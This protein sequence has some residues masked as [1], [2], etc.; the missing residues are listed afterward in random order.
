MANC[1]ITN[2]NTK[3]NNKP[4]DNITKPQC[5][6]FNTCIG[7]GK[8]IS[9]D[10]DCL[11]SKGTPSVIDGWYSEIH[12][13]N[14]CIIDARTAPIPI[15]TPPPCAPAAKPCD[16]NNNGGESDIVLNPE[17]CNLLEYI[18]GMLDARIYFGA[19]TGLTVTGCGTQN[20]PLVLNVTPQTQN[21]YIQSSTPQILPISGSGTSSDPF[22]ISHADSGIQA[23]M[24]GSFEVDR[25]GHIIAYDESR[26]DVITGIIDGNG[27]SLSITSGLLS[28]DLNDT[29]ID[30]GQYTLG[31]YTVTFNSTGQA[32][33]IRRDITITQGTYQLGNYNVTINDIG[34][35]T[36]ISLVDIDTTA[37][38]DT[39]IGS[40]RGDAGAVDIEREISFT[41][42]F[43]G[44]LH[45]EYRGLLS[46]TNL[47]P[48]QSMT[49]PSGFDIAIDGTS[50]VDQMI[51]VTGTFN[52]IVTPGNTI[53][54][55][56]GTSLN[57]ID[58]GPHTVTI[59]APTAL[60][61]QTDGV[62]RVQIVGKGA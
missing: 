41:T 61:T 57:A 13:V 29:G 32:T 45:V 53:V 14:G 30:A 56:R 15:Y 49:V 16:D 31:G 55:I 28:A 19:N 42:E 22:S 39:F 46:Q 33:D 18:S 40:Y 25:Y 1:R 58:A 26:D 24:Y 52:T 51:E 6:P 50:V 21:I 54:A 9:W 62:I 17:G 12:V 34:S 10:G 27:V 38:P 7:F 59:T 60:I 3:C 20:D 2:K 4:V 5:R 44:P 11:V 48:G 35:L 47:N 8:S 36:D 43:D 37:I 23:G